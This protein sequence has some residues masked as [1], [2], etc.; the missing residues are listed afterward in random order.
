MAN[1]SKLTPLLG[2]IVAPLAKS[3]HEQ[4]GVTEQVSN[5]IQGVLGPAPEVQK[6]DEKVL[7]P[8]LCNDK[9]A[10]WGYQVPT[11]NNGQKIDW[12]GLGMDPEK[13]PRVEKAIDDEYK[14]S[15]VHFI[16][17]TGK[18]MRAWDWEVVCP[19]SCPSRA[20]SKGSHAGTIKKGGPCP[21]CNALVHTRLVEKRDDQSIKAIKVLH[22]YVLQFY[23]S[24]YHKLVVV[25][26]P[27]RLVGAP[28]CVTRSSK[29]TSGTSVTVASPVM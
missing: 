21:G 20:S 26:H 1:P 23:I 3:F 16:V 4:L 18:P 7:V 15:H 13:L 6:W 29:A 2:D 28:A 25:H 11:T 9:K 10:Y 17:F 22:V 12:E 19:P 5:F 27:D 14:R 24:C 8:L